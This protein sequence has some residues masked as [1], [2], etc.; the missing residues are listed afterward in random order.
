MEQRNPKLYSQ[1]IKLNCKAATG[2]TIAAC[3]WVLWRLVDWR[4]KDS[5]IQKQYLQALWTSLIA[6][7]YLTKEEVYS[8]LGEIYTKE[9]EPIELMN[10]N[11]SDLKYNYLVHHPYIYYK[12]VN[13]LELA[14]YI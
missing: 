1:L 12:A 6:K 13:M 9:D 3:E 14:R 2:I 4:E 5:I 7:E 8:L 11:Y 10:S